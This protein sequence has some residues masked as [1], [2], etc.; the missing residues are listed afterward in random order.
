MISGWMQGVRLGIA[1]SKTKTVYLEGDR[2]AYVSLLE[3]DG[4]EMR[5]MGWLSNLVSLF[6]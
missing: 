3:V 2:R 5:L 4:Y 1:A 6:T